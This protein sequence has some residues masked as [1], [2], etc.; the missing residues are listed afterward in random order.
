[1]SYKENCLI[2]LHIHSTNSDGSNTTEELLMEFDRLGADIISFTDHNSVQC[3]YDLED[4][5]VRMIKELIVIPGVELCFSY[6]GEI[7]HILA[8]G[9]DIDIVNHFIQ[10]CAVEQ[11]EEEVVIL[12]LLKENCKKLNLKFDDKIEIKTGYQYEAYTLMWK[13]LNNYKEN[14]ER[15][16]FIESNSKFYWE[17]VNNKNS[18][19]FI[20]CSIN[21]P[22]MKEIIDLI[23]EANGL[24][25]LSHPFVYNESVEHVTRFLYEAITNNIDGLEYKHSSH[26]EEEIQFLKSFSLVNNLYTCGGSDFHEDSD[27]GTKLFT[28]FG[29]LA[30]KYTDIKDW[31]TVVNFI[32]YK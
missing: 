4:S 31:L 12:S 6:N 32:N 5:N 2:D 17:H 24:A 16:P 10:K 19:F 3:Y 28:G 13:S 15:Y 30:V 26:S 27:I 20:N 18:P 22:S 14:L 11:K 9:F 21:V 25:F 8:Y 23:H 1:M 29:N 7:R